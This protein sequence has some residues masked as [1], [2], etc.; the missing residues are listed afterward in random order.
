MDFSKVFLKFKID[1]K[2]TFGNRQ[3]KFLNF[4]LI[5]SAFF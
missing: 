2:K 4:R 5:L 1:F 3:K